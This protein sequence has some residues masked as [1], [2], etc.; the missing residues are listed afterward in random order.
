MYVFKESQAAVG[1]ARGVHNSLKIFYL[2]GL[3][4]YSIF[5]FDTLSSFFNISPDPCPK[6]AKNDCNR[7]E[8]RVNTEGVANIPTC[9]LEN[10]DWTC[11]I[12]YLLQD[13]YI[14]KYRYIEENSLDH[15]K[16]YVQRWLKTIADS[17]YAKWNSRKTRPPLTPNL[18]HTIFRASWPEGIWRLCVLNGCCMVY[19]YICQ[20]LYEY[21][22]PTNIYIYIS[23]VDILYMISSEGVHTNLL[24]FAYSCRKWTALMSSSN[25]CRAQ[26]WPESDRG[27]AAWYALNDDSCEKKLNKQLDQNRSCTRGKLQQHRC[28]KAMA[29]LQK[30]GFHCFAEYSRH[31]STLGMVRALTPRYSSNPV[32]V[33][34]F[35]HFFEFQ[36]VAEVPL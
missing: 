3:K 5:S 14:C 1:S 12:F 27:K 34:S 22:H 33:G 25:V 18:C 9:L 35:L 4:Q 32:H 19:I 24:Y 6:L 13:D 11:P 21:H 30:V 28:G 36:C 10:Q 2:P 15:V 7:D 29:S 26:P 17:W 31:I 16:I 20:P 8:K 23:T